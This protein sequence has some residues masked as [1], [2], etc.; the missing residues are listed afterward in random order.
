[1]LL[2][3]AVTPR[4]KALGPIGFFGVFDDGGH[5]GATARDQNHDVV[6]TVSLF[7]DTAGNG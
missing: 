7:G 1:L 2:T 3:T 5:V 6:Q 4:A